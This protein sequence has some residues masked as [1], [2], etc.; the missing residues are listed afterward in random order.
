M[1]RI[2]IFLGAGVSK[3]SGLP[4]GD[5]LTKQLWAPFRRS[6]TGHFEPSPVDGTDE[7]VEIIQE[8]LSRLSQHHQEFRRW[9][10]EL[11]R[12]P[13]LPETEVEPTYEELHS[14][15][16]RLKATINGYDRNALA[17]SFSRWALEHT[18][19]L[20]QQL[21]DEGTE[22]LNDEPPVATLSRQAV[23][24]INCVVRNALMGAPDEASFQLLI[25][26]IACCDQ[27]TIATLNHDTLVEQ[28]LDAEGIR[29][30]D[31]FGEEEEGIC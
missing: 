1:D 6:E 11:S 4:L 2:I 28:V 3:P 14:L 31:G 7:S 29:Y 25:D 21:V 13:M 18:E 19:D 10:I 5:G 9:Q 17:Y 20:A 27:V 16:S 22:P 23:F 12:V 26:L 30:V 24:Y 8:F 15:A